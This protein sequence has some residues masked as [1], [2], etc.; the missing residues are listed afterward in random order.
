[1]WPKC[2]ALALPLPCILPFHEIQM[3][4]PS[5]APTDD[6]TIVVVQA[7]T[8]TIKVAP[9][10]ADSTV[11][12]GLMVPLGPLNHGSNPNIPLGHLGVGCHL[13]GVCL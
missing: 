5:S 6:R 3:T 10:G 1:V 7:A 4:P 11:V 9:E 13:L 8:A 2:T 12:P